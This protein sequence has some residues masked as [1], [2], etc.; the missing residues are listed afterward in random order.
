[1]EAQLQSTTW[2]SPVRYATNIKGSDIASVDPA[3]GNIVP[4]YNPRQDRWLEH[5]QLIGA[6]II[7]M[8]PT[9]RATIRLLQLDHPDR[10]EER[11]LLIAA[12][13]NWLL[14]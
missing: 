3:A 12:G 13:M 9:G 10:I 11:D 5:F 6:Q 8:T 4:L 2:H 14:I 7:P 1:M